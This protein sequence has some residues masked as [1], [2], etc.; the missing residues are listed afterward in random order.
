MTDL[1]VLPRP[2]KSLQ[3]SAEKLEH[4]RPAK[5]KIVALVRKYAGAA[6]AKRKRNR[7]VYLDNEVGESR[8][9]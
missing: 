9:E 5:K 1:L 4:T 8:G 2:A 6:F 7:A 3:D